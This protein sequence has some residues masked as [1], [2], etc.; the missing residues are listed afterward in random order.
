LDWHN[1]KF[2]V[3]WASYLGQIQDL[4]LTGRHGFIGLANTHS[5]AKP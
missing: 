4:V 5:I 1:Q 3:L 2:A